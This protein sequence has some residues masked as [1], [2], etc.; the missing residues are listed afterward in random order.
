MG[1]LPGLQFNNNNNNNNNNNKT[2]SNTNEWGEGNYYYYY[3]CCSP[4][5]RV[6]NL[7]RGT[8]K[9]LTTSTTVRLHLALKVSSVCDDSVL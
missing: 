7:L 1:I 9:L 5:F 8:R 6:K 4:S 3:Y 2:N